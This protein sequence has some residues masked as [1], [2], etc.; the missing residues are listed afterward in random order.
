M[1]V[2]VGSEGP[3]DDDFLRQL[4]RGRLG[5]DKAEQLAAAECACAAAG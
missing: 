2:Q 5:Y 3:H 4:W 1:C